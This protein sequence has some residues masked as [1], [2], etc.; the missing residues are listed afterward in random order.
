MRKFKIQ[1]SKNLFKEEFKRRI[2]NFILNLIDF[3]DSLPKDKTCGIISSQLLR[4]GT[5][6][7][8]HYFEAKAASS[9]KRFY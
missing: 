6:I 4:S 8:A 7:G 2:Y 1:K 9:K 3:I 5:S